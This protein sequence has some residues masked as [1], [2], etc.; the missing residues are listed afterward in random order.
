[1]CFESIVFA[2]RDRGGRHGGHE[3]LARQHVAEKLRLAV[4]TAVGEAVGR[5]GL[6]ESVANSRHPSWFPRIFVYGRNDMYRRSL[7]NPTALY[8]QVL[9]VALDE[10]RGWLQNGRTDTQFPTPVLITTFTTSTPQQLA[11]LADVDILVSVQGAHLQ[12]TFVMHPHSAIL[13]LAP[14]H[15]PR[16]SFISRYGPM[17]PQQLYEQILICSTKLNLLEKDKRAQNVTLCPSDLSKVEV[18]VRKMIRGLL[19]PSKMYDSGWDL[20]LW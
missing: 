7:D 14:C 16:T 5:P 11:M 8:N 12:S 19:K 20:P 17:H 15:S 9:Q 3:T 10:Y 6:A 13:E 4:L 1:M 18:E 2:G